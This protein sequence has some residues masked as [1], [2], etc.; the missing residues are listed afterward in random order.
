MKYTFLLTVAAAIFLSSCS[1]GNNNQVDPKDAEDVGTASESALTLTVNT[2][3]SS[4]KWKGSKQLANSSHVG[5]IQ[6][7]GGSLSIENGNIVAGN[8]TVDMNTIKNEDLPVDGDYNQAA[9]EGHLKGNDFFS[10]EEFPSSSFEISKV[11]ALTNDENGNTHVISGNLTIKGISKNISIPSVVSISESG[12]TANAS[13]TI[14]RLD[15]NINYDKAG[16]DNF[17]QSVGKKLKDDFVKNEIEITISLVAQ[18]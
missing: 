8:F 7:S 10:V 1:G 18:N 5:T 6:I 13:F 16:I 2:E 4:L 12:V 11:E 3:K 17:L 14:N 9:L 15:W